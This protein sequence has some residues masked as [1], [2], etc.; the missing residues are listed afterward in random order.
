MHPQLIP[1]TE[2]YCFETVSLCSPVY[3]GNQHL[4]SVVSH[5]RLQVLKTPTAGKSCPPGMTKDLPWST[6]STCD[7]LQACTRQDPPTLSLLGSRPHLSPPRCMQFMI[8][9]G[10]FPR[11]HPPLS[12][13]FT[14]DCYF[15]SGVQPCV[16]LCFYKDTPLLSYTRVDTPLFLSS[17]SHSR[18]GPGSHLTH[19][20]L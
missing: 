15:S 7:N 5:T 13:R 1:T 17:M 12:L 14:S 9:R 20:H 18:V 2:F 10:R 4:P 3:S 8:V 11:S 19:V 16:A 6:L